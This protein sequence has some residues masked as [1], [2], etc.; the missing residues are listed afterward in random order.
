MKHQDGSSRSGTANDTK[1]SILP[2]GLA[3]SAGGEKSLVEHPSYYSPS[4]KVKRN[5]PG[6]RRLVRS[7]ILWS[8]H[9]SKLL[10]WLLVDIPIYRKP[11]IVSV[12][13]VKVAVIL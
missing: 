11:E 13:T 4:T 3:I 5:T 6:F 8:D 1:N 10:P 12:T 7:L 2:S 9:H